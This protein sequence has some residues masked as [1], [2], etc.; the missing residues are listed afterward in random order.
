MFHSSTAGPT[1]SQSEIHP[2]RKDVYFLKS[3]AK[4]R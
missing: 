1:K 4:S 2:I 3:K